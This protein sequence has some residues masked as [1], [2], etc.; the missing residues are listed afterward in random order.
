MLAVNG[1]AE[2]D[3]SFRNRLHDRATTPDIRTITMRIPPVDCAN[4]NVNVACAKAHEKIMCLIGDWSISAGR[5]IDETRLQWEYRYYR[6][7]RSMTMHTP[8]NAQ[9]SSPKEVVR[10]II[11]LL[12][13]G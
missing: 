7:I 5:S 10:T 4:A 2:P 1:Y 8:P 13:G 11:S 3:E 6:T 12:N 9:I